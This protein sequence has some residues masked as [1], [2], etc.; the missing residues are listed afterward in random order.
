MTEIKQADIQDFII[1]YIRCHAPENSEELDGN[2]N[3]VESG[4]LDSFAILS[5]I[6][7]IEGRFSVK[8]K[9]QELADSRLRT[10]GVLAAT[11]FAKLTEG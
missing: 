6:M 7:T 9:P 2:C 4:L 8:F 10:V 1:D 5:M 3:F 11:T